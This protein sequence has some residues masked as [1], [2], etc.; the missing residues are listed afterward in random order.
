MY[1]RIARFEGGGPEEAE[2]VRKYA[3]ERFLPELQKLDGF[4]GYAMLGDRDAGVGLG[5][6]LFETEEALEGGDRA[7][8]E[9][10]PPG[11]LSTSRRTSVE[12]YE[13]VVQDVRGTPTAAR[14]SRMEGPT[15]TVDEAIR[16][17][18]ED[19]LPRATQLDGWGGVL[20][21]VDRSTGKSMVITLWETP[22]ARQ[23]SEEAANQLRKDAA[24][25]GGGT[26][27]GVERYEVAALSL[28]AA[29]RT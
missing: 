29:A 24:E 14:A 23:A 19:V 17:A 5:I 1:A 18:Q 27:T 9:M 10:S 20:F 3:Q 8:N 2:L 21:L 13:V 6:T 22:E 12:K 25:T 16:H 7:L 15:D 28:T 4:A 26:I 11:E